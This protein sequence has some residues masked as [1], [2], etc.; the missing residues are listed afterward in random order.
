MTVIIVLNIATMATPF[1]KEPE[2]M[3]DVQENLNMAFTGAFA[4]EM[5]LK[6]FGELLGACV[7]C[8]AAVLG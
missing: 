6:V 2:L 3:M 7:C 8:G 4:V 5:L 1:Y